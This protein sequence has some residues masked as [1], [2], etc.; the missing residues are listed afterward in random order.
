MLLAS[1]AVVWVFYAIESQGLSGGIIV[2]WQASIV[3]IDVF[4]RCNQQ[5]VI[6][7]YEINRISWVLSA[8][9][10]SIDYREWMVLWQEALSLLE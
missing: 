4:Y 8:V 5:V 1:F 2:V 10:T 6:I 9:Y 3:T 7:I